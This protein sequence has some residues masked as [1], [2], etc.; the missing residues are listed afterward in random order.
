MFSFRPF[1]STPSQ[2]TL[3]SIISNIIKES[4]HITIESESIERQRIRWIST[5]QPNTTIILNK[6]KYILHNIIGEG[7]YGIV[8]KITDEN[9][10]YYA[11]KIIKC[12]E[13]KGELIHIELSNH[14]DIIKG[15]SIHK[16]NVS[17]NIS[18]T[19]AFI[20]DLGYSFKLVS[21]MECFF[22]LKNICKNI[23]DLNKHM[24]CHNDIKPLNII[25]QSNGRYCLIDYSLCSTIGDIIDNNLIHTLWYRP[26]EVLTNKYDIDYYKADIW[27]LGC[28][29]FELFTNTPL[30]PGANSNEQIQYI[31]KYIE[32]NDTEKYTFLYN[33]LFTEKQTDTY[34]NKKLFTDLLLLMLSN[35]NSRPLASILYNI[36]DEYMSKI[37]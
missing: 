34:S 29:I 7:A 16:M 19:N 15:Y 13:I 35:Q 14:L 36:I 26:L 28:T 22:I 5:L 10:N 32:L 24:L 18:P 25:R 17:S 21:Y 11:L 2:Q 12:S 8:W 9:N 31:S 4:R 1:K 20:M 30:F 33:K 37:E 23:L 6:Q 27:A 3:Q